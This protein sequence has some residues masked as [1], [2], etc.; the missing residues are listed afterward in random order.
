MYK[1]LFFSLTL[2]MFS[3]PLQKSRWRQAVEGERKALMSR[4]MDSPSTR[5]RSSLRNT[6]PD[7][8]LRKCNK[9][10]AIILYGKVDIDNNRVVYF[11][12][13][14]TKA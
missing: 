1:V 12:F 8:F 9:Y 5:D 10:M 7:A 6:W 11:S 14:S 4:L 2:T 3:P 13:E